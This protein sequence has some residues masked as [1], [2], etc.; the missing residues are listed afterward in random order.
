MHITSTGL[1]VT[2]K[3]TTIDCTVTNASDLRDTLQV[4]ATMTDDQ[5]TVNF[6]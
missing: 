4:T 3:G 2:D 6:S 5:G 1:A